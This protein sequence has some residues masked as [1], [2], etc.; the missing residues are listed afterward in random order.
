MLSC[1]LSLRS[2]DARVLPVSNGY[3]QLAPGPLTAVADP[4][5]MSAL[6]ACE[7]LCHISWT[8]QPLLG[9][10]KSNA[11]RAPAKV[12]EVPSGCQISV[13]VSFNNS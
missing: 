8:N 12:S 1:R 2:N 7:V 4:A 9:V 10:C 3:R 5:A 13:S 11:L 6:L